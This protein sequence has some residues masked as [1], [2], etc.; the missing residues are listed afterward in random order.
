MIRLFFGSPGCGKTTTAVHNIKLWQTDKQHPYSAF[1]TNFDCSLSK[2]I[3]LENLGEWTL[4]PGSHLTVD[5]SGIE[6][7]NRKYKSMPQTLIAWFKL[8]RHYRVDVDFYSQSWEDTDITILRLAD[9]YWHVRRLGIFTLCRKVRKFVTIKKD[10]YQIVSGYEYVPIWRRFL[11]F[12]FH[13]RSWYV[14]WRRPYYNYFNSWTTPD[15]PVMHDEYQPFAHSPP[16][17]RHPIRRLIWQIKQGRK[18]NESV[19]SNPLDAEQSEV[20]GVQNADE[21]H[22]EDVLF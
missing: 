16:S 8:H 19:A 12:P 11:P 1:Y 7:N 20:S 22:E 15:T 10:D 2:E 4:P 21:V 18:A 9:E 13:V 14:Y 5:E 3:S 17:W 6:F